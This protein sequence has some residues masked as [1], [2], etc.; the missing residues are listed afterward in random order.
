MRLASRSSARARWRTVAGCQGAPPPWRPPSAATS[1]AASTPS[2]T[3]TGASHTTR[4]CSRARMRPAC[5]GPPWNA[6]RP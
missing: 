6:P 4:A 3:P 2:G 5:P 1:A